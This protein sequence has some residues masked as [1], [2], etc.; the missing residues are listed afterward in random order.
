MVIGFDLWGT[1]VKS[2]PLFKDA[3]QLLFNKHFPSIDSKKFLEVQKRVSERLDHLTELAGFQSTLLLR[4]N[5]IISYLDL[6]VNNK[7]VVRSM[8]GFLQD[9]EL[10]FTLFPP[11]VYDLNTL[12]VFEQLNK[13]GH[14]TRIVSNTVFI[15]HKPL[16]Q[17]VDRYFMY[18]DFTTSDIA[19]ISKPLKGICDTEMDFFIGDNPVTDGGY[20]KAIGAEFFQINT[21][22]KTIKDAYEY[23]KSNTKG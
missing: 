8:N 22:N 6:D 15:G 20:A 23:I 3:K 19:G 21:N 13:D 4:R 17:I 12:E 10:L 5:L 18:D 2:N 14:K 9:Y 16:K 11:L 1:L 7:E